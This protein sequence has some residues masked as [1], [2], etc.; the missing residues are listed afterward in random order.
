[1]RKFGVLP[2]LFTLALPAAACSRAV[3][4]QGSSSQTQ[5]RTTVV[6]DN[7]ASLDMN[8][9]VIRDGGMR[10]R[11]GTATAHLKNTFTI[12]PTLLFGVTSLRFLADPI[13]S[14][15][16]PVSDDILVTP[17]DQVVLTIPPG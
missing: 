7:Q 10:Q 2:L 13:G 12:P 1:M 14:S 3:Q 4:T 8:I 6:V 5:E 16:T 17:G 9:Y 11:L 15:R